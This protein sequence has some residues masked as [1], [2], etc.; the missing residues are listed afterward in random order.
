MSQFWKNNSLSIVLFTLLIILSIG[1]LFVGVIDISLS[2]LL[3]SPEQLELLAI[4][5]FP[6]LMAI[7]M[8]VSY[9]HLTLPTI[10]RV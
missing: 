3:S 6:R 1:S 2:E 9:T 10:L 8:A 4:S 5:R 7:L